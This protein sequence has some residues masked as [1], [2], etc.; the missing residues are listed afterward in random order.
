MWKKLLVISIF[1]IIVCPVLSQAYYVS[2]YDN[3]TIVQ[4]EVKGY[5]EFYGNNKI[6]LNAVDT[7]YSPNWVATVDGI[8]SFSYQIGGISYNKKVYDCTNLT[9]TPLNGKN[10]FFY[11]MDRAF[12]GGN[13]TFNEMQ[14]SKW[15][16]ELGKGYNIDHIWLRGL[17]GELGGTIKDGERWEIND[18]RI[19]FRN[20]NVI[21]N[22]DKWNDNIFFKGN[23]TMNVKVTF[24]DNNFLLV[25]MFS[26]TWPPLNG[27]LKITDFSGTVVQS[28]KIFSGDLTIEG[29]EITI[30]TIKN[31][32]RD[33]QTPDE[34]PR[35]WKIEV[36]FTNGNI[37]GYYYP[38]WGVGAIIGVVMISVLNVIGYM[39]WKTK[40]K[41]HRIE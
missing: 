3:R 2:L 37:N 20:Q 9:I 33:Y 25:R 4:G 27:R 13:V 10:G 19:S 31:P 38:Y 35:Y 32:Y 8:E 30:R 17:S 11:D 24:F 26:I 18:I 6:K 14:T 41:K 39:Y 28:G 15:T 36:T 5:L 21:V 34:P 22:N 40:N 29:K 1:V 7:I 23:G 12:M 16:G